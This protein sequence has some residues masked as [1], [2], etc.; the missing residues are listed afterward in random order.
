MKDLI[1]KILRE[2]EEE[3]TPQKLSYRGSAEDRLRLVLNQMKSLQGWDT[4][5]QDIE[6]Y[7]R[8]PYSSNNLRLSLLDILKYVGSTYAADSNR[9][10]SYTDTRE[11]AYWFGKVF[12][13]NGG[14]RRDFQHNEIQLIELPIYEMSGDYTEEVFEF[15][16]GWGSIV[17]AIDEEEAINYFEGDIGNYI[18]DSETNDSDYGDAYDAENVNIEETRW[19]KF[20]PKWVGL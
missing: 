20:D 5:I 17:G 13:I 18:E 6:Q 12:M 11:L 14:Y 15:R 2:V 7:K 3:Q 16:T 19:L 4:F 10:A 1:R 9:G 8:I